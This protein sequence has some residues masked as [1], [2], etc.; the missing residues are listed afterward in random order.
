M[1]ESF[2]HFAISAIHCLRFVIGHSPT[3]LLSIIVRYGYGAVCNTEATTE[4]GLPYIGAIAKF[5]IPQSSTDPLLTPTFHNFKK[6]EF[7]GEA[8]FVAR[9]GGEMEDDGWLVLLVHNVELD[10]SYF[11]VI[12]ARDMEGEPVAKITLPQRV[13]WGLHGLFVPSN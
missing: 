9:D 1:H 11:Y 5:Q 8:V 6:G 4:S 13:P 12:D 2:M 3:C 10:C 7:G